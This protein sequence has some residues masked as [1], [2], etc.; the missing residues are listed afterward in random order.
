MSLRMKLFSSLALAAIVSLPLHADIESD[1]IVDKQLSY[2]IE[3]QV[4]FGDG[5]NPLWLNANKYG[6]SSL[7]PNNGYLRL[8]AEG[9]NRTGKTKN[10]SIEYGVDLAA[11]YNFTSSFI[12]QQL[13]AGFKY[14]KIGL[15][16]G[17]KEHAPHL[18]NK[19]LSSGSQTFGINARPIPDIRIE[20][21]DYFNLIPN[22]SWLSMKFHFGYGLTTDKNWQH[23]FVKKGGR[24]TNYV[25]VHTKSGFL[26]IG[27]EE[28]FPLVAE[29]G[30]E[31]ATQFGGTSYNMDFGGYHDLKMSA[32][33]KDFFKAI[34]GGGSDAIDYYNNSQGNSL[35]SWLFS[36][37]YKLKEAKVRLYMDHFFEDH[38]QI[39]LQYGWK[40]GLYGCEITLPD[41]PIVK[42]A[43][44][45]YIRTDYQSGPIYHDGNSTIGDQIS[46]IDNYY[47]H[48]IYTGWQHWGQAIGNPLFTSPLYNKDHALTFSNNRFRAHHFG[49]SGQPIK[50]LSYRLLYTYSETW[51][52][53][54][55]PFDDKKYNT[56][57]LT[58]I[59]FSPKRLGLWHTDGN[60]F[61][62]SF[63]F[64]KGNLM[65]NNTGFQFTLISRGLFNL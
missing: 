65:G 18:K 6:M 50:S 24:H 28:K 38:S 25:F 31:W 1:E 34:Y 40:D 52:T 62:C 29:G 21:P 64:D 16:L 35:G 57:F 5:N 58:E 55:F 48:T 45:E 60:S 11:A 36:L 22:K 26:R 41:N 42:S 7:N 44:Y 9:M 61:R 20:T 8:A 13:Y 63:A 12:V 19:D 37:S 15:W 4:T 54:E 14:K 3:R 53:Y 47:N 10:W 2:N 39:F 30:M 43:V 49:F 56:S 51:G 23:D 59:T 33:I 46:A 27:D 17:S 32:G